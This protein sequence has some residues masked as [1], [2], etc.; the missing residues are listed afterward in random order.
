MIGRTHKVPS[1]LPP[2][3][4]ADW[5]GA[6][7]LSVPRAGGRSAGRSPRTRSGRAQGRE[8]AGRCVR[9]GAW[10]SPGTDVPVSACAAATRSSS[11]IL[12]VRRWAD[13]PGHHRR[14]RHVQP[15]RRPQLRG[16][17][18][19]PRATGTTLAPASLD[20]AFVLDGPGEYEVKEVLLTGVRTY[21]D[22]AKGGES[23]QAGR[24]RRRARR[25]AHDPSRRRYVWGG[26]TTS[27]FDCS[28]FIHYV[29][30]KAGV[31]MTRTNSIGYFS[32]SF[33]VDNPQPGDLVFFKNTYQAGISHLGVYLGNGNFIHAG[34]SG[35]AVNNVND[36]YWKSK[37]DSYK[38]FYSVAN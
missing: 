9:I 16:P 20:T 19:R 1:S 35:I 24:L 26:Q 31:S 22:D 36:T 29:Y 32:R 7:G 3:G 38:R 14:H 5:A 17:R 23:R 15:S 12:S 34:S 2:T 25:A 4:G 28:G 33:Y 30:N 13:R 10:K 8:R 18:A 21:R 11:P 27:G 37:F 6:S